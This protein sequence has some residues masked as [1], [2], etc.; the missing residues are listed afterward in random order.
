[1]HK[2]DF[3]NGTAS[4]SYFDFD[5]EVFTSTECCFRWLMSAMALF[6]TQLSCQRLQSSQA[7][8]VVSGADNVRVELYAPQ[9]A[10]ERAAQSAVLFHP[11]ENFFDALALALADGVASVPSGASIQSRRLAALHHGNVRSD[12]ASPQVR[13]KILAVIALVGADAGRTYSLASLPI[14]HRL[15]RFRFHLRSLGHLEVDAQSVAI[16]H[17]GMASVAE[18]RFLALTFAPQ[19]GVLVRRRAM[20][21]IGASLAAEV[22]H[23]LIVGTATG[24]RRPVLRPHA[25]R[26]RGL[27]LDQRAIHREVLIGQQ[28]QLPRLADHRIEEAASKLSIDQ[29][30]AQSREVRLIQTPFLQ[31]HVQKPAK[32]DVVVEHLAEHPIRAHRVQRDQQARLEQPLRRN[33]RPAATGV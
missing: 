1:M 11:T 24:T 26:G 14:Q 25:L 29:P 19:F 33:R 22:D 28:F 4:F 2:W 16:L 23:A 12:L 8:Q 20:R 31:I 32:Q 3:G 5:F 6:R 18:L 30:L 17:E 9:T 15:G 10:R 7:Q 27:S 21:G 13:N